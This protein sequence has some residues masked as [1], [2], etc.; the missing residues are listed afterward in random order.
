MSLEQP[1]GGPSPALPAAVDARHVN[2]KRVERAKCLGA[3]VA[4]V[5]AGKVPILQVVQNVVLSCADLAAHR[6]MVLGQTANRQ[7][8]HFENVIFQV[9]TMA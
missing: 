2:L 9:E 7:R 8:V 3:Q 1:H 6:T 5:V 4:G